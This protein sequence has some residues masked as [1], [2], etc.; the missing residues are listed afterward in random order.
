MGKCPLGL[1]VVRVRDSRFRLP[2][3]EFL[4]A[5][6]N[7]DRVAGEGGQNEW[8]WA[9][10]FRRSAAAATQHGRGAFSRNLGPISPPLRGSCPPR[11]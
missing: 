2:H 3:F 11:L 9:G 8:R 4:L 6:G 7:L 5:A 1:D 10:K